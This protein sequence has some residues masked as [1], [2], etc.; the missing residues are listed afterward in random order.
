MFS[1]IFDM[2]RGF[3]NES[4]GE[5]VFLWKHV[6]LSTLIL[7][8]AYLLR[9]VA[10]DS[11][12]ALLS[13]F[14]AKTK[15]QADDL[16]L[17]AI[18]VPARTAIV[19]LS[20]LWAVYI[21]PLEAFPVVEKIFLAAFRVTTIILV[22]WTGVR[23]IRVLT[24]LLR[25][26]INIKDAIIDD[27]L[28]PF[29]DQIL[30]IVVV[31][32]GFVMILQELGYDP[33]GLLAGLGLGGLA[34]ALA[35]KDTLQNFFGSLMILTDQPLQVGDF[36]EFKGIEGTVEIIGFRSTHVR[37]LDRS[38]VQIPN[39]L[40]AMDPVRNYTRRDRRRIQ[41]TVGITYECTPAMMKAAITAI[42]KILA[43]EN[44][45]LQ[46]ILVVRFQNFGSSSL[47]ILV[48]CFADTTAWAEWL[49]IQESVMLRIYERFGELG[50]PF[51]YP[52][53]T[54]HMARDVSPD[55]E[56]KCRLFLES[57]G[58]TTLHEPPSAAE[59]PSGGQS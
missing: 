52:A 16:L 34:F 32:I 55:M 4:I 9:K 8:M 45:I 41:F 7:S 15:T 11:V 19:L 14:A 2:A 6:I 39:G 58:S 47:D 21:L 43:E 50:I 57:I 30:R 3:F 33:S 42:E 36:I 13:R 46:D 1:S 31:L 59:P 40:L 28:I 48:H 12:L 10:V 5:S 20:V 22:C 25:G 18:R 38:I 49:T 24:Y 29:V 23:A 54:V 26:V 37:L 35:A 51:A 17:E 53:M 27:R 56:D 44:R